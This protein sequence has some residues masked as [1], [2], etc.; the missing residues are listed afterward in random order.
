MWEHDRARGE[1]TTNAMKVDWSFENNGEV[2]CP[3]KV[4][5]FDAYLEASPDWESCGLESGTPTLRAVHIRINCTDLCPPSA[6]PIGWLRGAAKAYVGL[7]GSFDPK[8]SMI[9]IRPVHVFPGTHRLSIVRPAFQRRIKASSLG[10]LG[11]EVS[12][13]AWKG[14]CMRSLL[15]IYHRPTTII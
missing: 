2:L 5:E 9:D 13:Y 15:S 14:W 3:S 1:T 11:I 10:T 8:A 4:T 12:E 6:L 7:Q